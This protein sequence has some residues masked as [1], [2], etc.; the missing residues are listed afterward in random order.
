MLLLVGIWVL[1]NRQFIIDQVTVWQFQP[2]SS[3]AALADESG[4]SERGK[5]LYYASRPELNDRTNFNDNCATREQ[6]SIVLGCYAAQRIFL[7]DV[8]DQ[9]ISGIKTVVAAHEMLHAAYERLGVDETQSL[10][11]LL[12]DQLAKTTDQDL[13]DLVEMYEE[14]EPGQKYNE[15][16][17][18]FATEVADLSLDLENYYEKYFTDRTKVVKA[19]QE[20]SQ[21]FADLKNQATV[22]QSDLKTKEDRIKRLTANYESETTSLASDITAFNARAQQTDG[23]GSMAEFELAREELLTRQTALTELSA[24][25]NDLIDE[26]NDGVVSLNALGIEIDKLN[27]SLDSTIQTI[28]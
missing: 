8:T 14:T 26:Y 21:V 22:L 7:F 10:N 1:L 2:S 20:Y 15:L 27:E 3:V 28:E 9:R 6:Q 5:F 23:F 17:S 25:I 19:Y 24:T 11:R 12:E 4:M 16:H 13:L 18:L